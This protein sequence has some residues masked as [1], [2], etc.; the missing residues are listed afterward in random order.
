VS[1]ERSL[2]DDVRAAWDELANFWDQQMQAGATW[3]R[4]LIQPSVER[5]LRL[6]RGERVLEN[7]VRERGARAPH[8]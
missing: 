2:H 5:L 7:R 4:H 6:E 3:Q 1:D 8:V